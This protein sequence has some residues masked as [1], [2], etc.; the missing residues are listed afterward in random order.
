MRKNKILMIVITVL[1]LEIN[2]QQDWPYSSG[3]IF[4]GSS[5]LDQ[6]QS[7]NY[8]LLQ[9]KANGT[10]FLNSP[11]SVHLRI[12]NGDKLVIANNGNVGI[13][14][15]N[16]QHKLDLNG[17][18]FSIGDGGNG[19]PFKIWAGSSGNNNHLRIGSDIGHY[20]DAVVE[21]YQN[22]SG[23][24]EQNPGKLVVNGNL[25]IGTNTPDSRLHIKDGGQQIKLGVGNN[26]SGY[27]FSVGVN[28]DGINFLNNSNWRGFNYANNRD[29]LLKITYLGN[30]GIGTSNPGSYRLAVKGKIR[31]EEIKVETGWADY[32]FKEDYDLPTLEEVEKH[33]REKGHL[34]N[35]PSAKE[36]E[37]N[38]V[39]LGKMNKLLLE[40][41]EEQMLYILKQ[42][43]KLKKQDKRI[44][45]LEEKLN[46]VI[47]LIKS[48]K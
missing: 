26:T 16:P 15:S 4:F 14:T 8:S 45:E 2:A 1:S 18:V 36:V 13:G 41:I 47:N 12:D 3:Y 6:S 42:E 17:G 29:E 11:E 39:E 30:V 35:I 38:G 37:E 5:L 32:V 10:T 28:D 34:I 9:H 20:G 31:A 22:Y 48:P 33:I 46:Q 24:G 43:E 7:V 21:L 19:I 23:G 25:G 44:A 40:K 27:S